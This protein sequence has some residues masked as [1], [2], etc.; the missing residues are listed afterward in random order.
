MTDVL[1]VSERQACRVIGT[2]RLR[3][4]LKPAALWQRWLARKHR[5][6]HGFASRVSLDQSTS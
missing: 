6:L 4:E 2:H 1:P 5:G 3:D